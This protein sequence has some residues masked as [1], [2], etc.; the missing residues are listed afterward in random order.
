MNV[1]QCFPPCKCTC[2]WQLC[3]PRLWCRFWLL[4]AFSHLLVQWRMYPWHVIFS[5]INVLGWDEMNL[6]KEV[7]SWNE[8]NRERKLKLIHAEGGAVFNKKQSLHW[9][10]PCTCVFLYNN[11]LTLRWNCVL[12]N[13]RSP[14]KELKKT[15]IFQVQYWMLDSL[16]LP[17][18]AFPW[19]IL[20][21]LFHFFDSF[22]K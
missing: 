3:C 11:A 16:K 15:Y 10:L 22:A 13:F 5:C 18:Y 17:W 14:S 4:C 2:C 1:G 9:N 6:K 12:E 20:L 7:T 19:G 21:N 8:H